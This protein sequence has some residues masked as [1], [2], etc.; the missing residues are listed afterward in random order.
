MCVWSSV[1]NGSIPVGPFLR[2][3]LPIRAPLP[4]NPEGRGCDEAR[5]PTICRHRLVLVGIGLVCRRS[6]IFLL[7]TLPSSHEARGICSSNGSHLHCKVFRLGTYAWLWC[8]PTASSVTGQILEV[9]RYVPIPA[10]HA[11]IRRPRQP[12]VCEARFA[13]VLD[14]DSLRTAG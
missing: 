8:F 12:N 9:L 1:G 14:P 6:S 2:L 5:C 4:P 3:V 7:L 10:A 13:C 11:K